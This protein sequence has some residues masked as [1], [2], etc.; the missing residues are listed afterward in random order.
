MSTAVTQS[1]IKSFALGDVVWG[2]VSGYPWWPAVIV[3]SKKCTNGSQEFVVSFLAEDA[4]AVLGFGKVADF[5]LHFEHYSKKC[6]AGCFLRA[7]RIAQ[8]I[9]EGNPSLMHT[10][11]F[12]YPAVVPL[13]IRSART[14]RG[15]LLDNYREKPTRNDDEV[16]KGKKRKHRHRASRKVQK[17]HL[18]KVEIVDAEA[19]ASLNADN[20]NP[21]PLEVKEEG[22][23]NTSA[24]AIP[25][26]EEHA[27]IPDKSQVPT[28]AEPQTDSENARKNPTQDAVK[29]NA[30][31]S[32][33]YL[34]KVLGTDDARRVLREKERV[35]QI[36]T[37]I[38]SAED[39]SLP[40]NL[41]QIREKKLGKCAKRL[42]AMCCRVKGLEDLK[43]VSRTLLK[44]LHD[45]V[46]DKYFG[47][48]AADLLK[49]VK[50]N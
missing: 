5:Q 42:F 46:I 19:L 21:P 2:K 1:A 37:A 11:E 24:I 44:K 22:N 12:R 40:Y 47:V 28:I 16:A 7:I 32:F 14:G 36:V 49:R 15:K 33:G 26:K 3:N 6:G 18:S 13:E 38:L 23:M 20:P 41:V 29:F 39:T 25:D 9:I 50:I 4:H 35:R 30:E 34:K 8:V 17:T 27:Q 43:D 31:E 45:H 10:E 48:P